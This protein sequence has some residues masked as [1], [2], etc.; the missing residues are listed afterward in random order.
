MS[1]SGYYLTGK[2]LFRH[3]DPSNVDALNN[4]HFRTQLLATPTLAKDQDFVVKK[5]YE[6]V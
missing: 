4:P 2:Q 5:S 6:S 3:I 1:L